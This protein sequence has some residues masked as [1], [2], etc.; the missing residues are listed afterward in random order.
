MGNIGRQLAVVSKNLTIFFLNLKYSQISFI[1]LM[2][3][4]PTH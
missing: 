2:T 3:L 1:S 4:L